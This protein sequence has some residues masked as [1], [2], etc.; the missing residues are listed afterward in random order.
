MSNLTTLL[1]R[2]KTGLYQA[3]P[4]RR[5]HIPKGEGKVRPIGIPT[6]EDKVLQR[7]VVMLLEPVYEQDFYPFSYGFRPGKSAPVSYTHLT[8]P[9]S[10]LV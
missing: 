7:A 8:L 3:P 2:A 5:A 9:T 4:V 1:D 10:D 6:I